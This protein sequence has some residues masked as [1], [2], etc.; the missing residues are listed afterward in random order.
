MANVE[1]SHTFNATAEKCFE[2]LL[3]ALKNRR[4]EIVSSNPAEKTVIVR[5]T[6]S[7]SEKYTTQMQ[8]IPLDD[9]T[10]AIKTMYRRDLTPG[11]YRPM[12][13]TPPPEYNMHIS[14]IFISVKEFL[15]PAFDA[16]KAQADTER[17]M[18]VAKQV[19][20]RRLI[21]ITIL[22]IFTG[23][24]WGFIA[25]GFTVHGFTTALIVALIAWIVYSIIGL[26]I[27]RKG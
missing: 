14:R 4:G 9:A 6:G 15:D 20:A 21:I 13:A 7:L 11:F 27:A 2:G 23:L 22:S 24:L 16:A 26:L 17:R 3:F 1:M 19:V 12:G 8:C 10:T 18:K 5:W 25:N